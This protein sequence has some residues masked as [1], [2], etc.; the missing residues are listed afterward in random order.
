MSLAPIKSYEHLLFV[1][2]A[3]NQIVDAT[4]LTELQYLVCVD[5]SDNA[6]ATPL[7]LPQP[8]LQVRR[9]RGE[10]AC[11]KPVFDLHAFNAKW[12]IDMH[13]GFAMLVAT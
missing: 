2:V 11:R 6:I 5:L 3:R 4:P 10:A 13:L 1:N 8:H 12:Y 9:K 7:A